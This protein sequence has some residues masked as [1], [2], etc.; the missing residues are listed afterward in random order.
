GV[1]G[2]LFPTASQATVL[3]DQTGTDLDLVACR[4]AT[5]SKTELCTRALRIVIGAA[6][7]LFGFAIRKTHAPSTAPAPV[8]LREQATGRLSVGSPHRNESHEADGHGKTGEKR[9]RHHSGILLL[10][11]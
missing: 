10:L 3:I 6:G 11:T 1:E 8:E 5:D 7:N 9:T 2:P 4:G